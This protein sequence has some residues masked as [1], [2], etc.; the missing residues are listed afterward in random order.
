MHTSHAHIVYYVM[1]MLLLALIA[2]VGR[3]EQDV[4]AGR[5][6]CVGVF[7]PQ[8]PLLSV[9]SNGELSCMAVYTI[10]PILAM[11]WRVGGLILL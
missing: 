6:C 5:G 7:E 8:G 2:V 1:R 4:L 9:C 10:G 11:Q 3:G